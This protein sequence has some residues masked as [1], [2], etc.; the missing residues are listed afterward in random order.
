MS[1]MQKKFTMFLHSIV[2]HNSKKYRKKKI[3]LYIMV[4]L[5]DIC[6]KNIC[7]IVLKNANTF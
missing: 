2:K 1:K 6:M 3:S 5:E 7:Y 4:A